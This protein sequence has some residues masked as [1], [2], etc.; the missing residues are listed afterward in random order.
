M[1]L[2]MRA[3]PLLLIGTLSMAACQIPEQD[4]EPPRFPEWVVYLESDFS[5]GPKHIPSITDGVDV[6]ASERCGDRKF[7]DVWATTSTILQAAARDRATLEIVANVS[8]GPVSVTRSAFNRNDDEIRVIEDSNKPSPTRDRERQDRIDE[9]VLKATGDAKQR[10]LEALRVPQRV[11]DVF[12]SVS[13]LQASLPER[14]R[15][16]SRLTAV[17]VSDMVHYNTAHVTQFI[18]QDGLM[19]MIFPEHRKA[20]AHLRDRDQGIANWWIN[21]RRLEPV[22]TPE[23]QNFE[24]R[25]VPVERCQEGELWPQDA[26]PIWT[27]IRGDV[28]RFWTDSFRALGAQDVRWNYTSF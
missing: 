19:N 26:E 23:P 1:G 25:I 21:N 6:S 18:P 7:E 20:L 10:Y 16:S 13:A 3:A 5:L 28:E 11:Q 15:R 24:V 4:T 17:F 8:P 2:T 27:L 14:F 22:P 9:L 12:Q